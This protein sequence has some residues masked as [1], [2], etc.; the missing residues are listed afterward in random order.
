MPVPGPQEEL[1]IGQE[2]KQL[3]DEE[4]EGATELLEEELM[5]LFPFMEKSVVYR[6]RHGHRCCP[7]ETKT[8]FVSDWFPRRRSAQKCQMVLI[9]S[10]PAAILREKIESLFFPAGAS[11]SAGRGVV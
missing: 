7:P 6:S 2:T 4:E 3:L 11:L 9:R 1:K 5:C 8:V 10:E